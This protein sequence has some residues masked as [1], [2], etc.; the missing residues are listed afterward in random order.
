MLTY[1]TIDPIAISLGPLD[2]RWYGIAYVMGILG[3]WQLC[4]WLA[5]RGYSDIP[6]AHLS[7][8]I[9]FATIGILV[10]G[11][12]GHVFLY[13]FDYYL[14]NPTEIIQIWKPGMAFHGGIFGVIAVTV[15]FCRS[16]SI[17]ILKLLDLISV[18]APIGL[19]FGRIANFIN[20]ELWGRVTDSPLGIVFPFAGPYPRHPSQLYEAALEGILL[21]ALQLTLILRRKSLTT[22]NSLITKEGALAGIFLCGYAFSRSFVE[23]FREPEDGF[24]GPLTAGQFWSLPLLIAGIILIFRGRHARV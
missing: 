7:D 17:S 15:W 4:A 13:E 18:G 20:G 24:I 16:R 12:L 8:F 19:F 22:Q 1:P 2:I 3:A 14:Q 9:P 6:A 23:F 10:G 11:R 21:F 5:K